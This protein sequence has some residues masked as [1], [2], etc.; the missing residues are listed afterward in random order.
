MKTATAKR[1]VKAKGLSV[2]EVER[3]LDAN[4]Y[5]NEQWQWTHSSL[6]HEFLFQQM[7]Q[8]A[9]VTSWSGYKCA[10][11]CG[12]REPLPEQDLLVE[13]T[14]MELISPNSTCQDIEELYWDVYKLSRLPGWGRS[15]EATEEWLCQ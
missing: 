10:I 7:F 9:M 1:L 11:C 14:A 4:A 2:R 6:H 8:H 12:Q 15:E 13:P 5:L 3:Q